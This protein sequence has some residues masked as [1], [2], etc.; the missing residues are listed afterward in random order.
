MSSRRRVVLL[1]VSAVAC[2]SATAVYV[3]AYHGTGDGR[4]AVPAAS[5]KASAICGRLHASLPAKV[6]GLSRRALEPASRLTAGWGDPTVVLRCGVPRP[7]VLTPGSKTYNPTSDAAD[8]NGVSWLVQ[9]LEGGGYRFTT[10]GRTAFVEVTVPTEYAPEVNPLTDLAAAV[11][12]TVP[13]E[14]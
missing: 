4:V 5:A 2:L 10:T 6:D 14:L 12:R 11:K 8:V 9:Q 7:E 1:S 3:F 13:T